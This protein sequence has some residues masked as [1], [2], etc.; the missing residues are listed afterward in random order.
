MRYDFLSYAGLAVIVAVAVAV[1]I[2]QI[3]G[4]G[5]GKR[6]KRDRV[7]YDHLIELQSQVRCLAAEQGGKL[8]DSLEDTENCQTTAAYDPYTGAAYVY[9]PTSQLSYQLCADFETPETRA[10]YSRAFDPT[11][12]CLVLDIRYQRR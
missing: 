12:G 7:R 6:E 2:W 9:R 8:P 5:Q 11:S 10:F 3:G 4:P 1:G